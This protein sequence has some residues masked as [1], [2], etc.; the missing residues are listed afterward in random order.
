MIMNTSLDWSSAASPARQVRR[1]NGHV[2]KSRMVAFDAKKHSGK[3]H[4]EGK[5]R[6]HKL[7]IIGRLRQY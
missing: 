2:Y 3:Y 7:L 4:S 1:K 6:K 5:I